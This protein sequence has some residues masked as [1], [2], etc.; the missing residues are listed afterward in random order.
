MKEKSLEIA[1]NHLQ[2]DCQASRQKTPSNEKHF[3]Q[4][5]NIQYS[6]FYVLKFFTI[7]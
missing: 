6:V 1:S 3:I 5:K 7:W 4:Y 2:L